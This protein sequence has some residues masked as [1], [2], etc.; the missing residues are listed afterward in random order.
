MIQIQDPAKWGLQ[1]DRDGSLKIGKVKLTDLALTYGTPLHVINQ[2]RLTDT[3]K[4]FKKTVEI[5]YPGAVSV[6]YAFKC[7]SV[8]Y[9]VNL[10]KNAG[11]KAEVTNEFEYELARTIDFKPN[12]VIVNGPCKK[13]S[14]LQQCVLDAVRLIVIDSLNELAALQIICDQLDQNI[15]ILLRINPDYIPK[16]MNRSTATGSRK[17]CA[18]GLDLKSGEVE[19]AL[20]QLKNS[21]RIH[22]S[23]FHF[24]IGTGIR[25]PKDYGRVIRKLF[26][27]FDVTSHLGFAIKILDVGGGF[28]SFTTR[29]LTTSEM[30]IYQGLNRMPEG[31]DAHDNRMIGEFACEISTSL[32]KYFTA[33]LLPEII[34]EPGRSIASPNQLLILQVHRIKQ[35]KGITKWLI[36]DGGL[37]TVTMPTYY[38][39]HEIFLCNDAKRSR[40]ELTTITGPCCFAA[41]IVYKNKRMPQVHSGEFIAIMDAGAYF[42]ALESSFGFPR[43]AIVAVKNGSHVL[44]RKRETFTDMI[45]RDNIFNS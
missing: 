10:L 15:N 14:F 23:G 12:D 2:T 44:A 16:G 32:L 11:L 37:G 34:Y 30:L 29:E 1:V 43:P 31:I 38:E 20:N 19:N 18:F 8:P 7:N 41:D 28:A 26:P 24:H 33:A 45:S 21:K 17:G 5:S 13:N 39:Y 3:A 42:T 9:L 40:R 27:L 36:T 22:F 6:H 35:R 4:N 25:N